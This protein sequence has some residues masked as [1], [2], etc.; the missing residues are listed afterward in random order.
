VS[1]ASTMLEEAGIDP[2][3]LMFVT[4]ASNTPGAFVRAV[5]ELSDTISP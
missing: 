1:Y 4:V 5:Q 3:R 2:R